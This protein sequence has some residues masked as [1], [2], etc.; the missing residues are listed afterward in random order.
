MARDPEGGGLKIDP[1]TA[2]VD[3][4]YGQTLDP[5]GVCDE[6]ELPD[7]FHCVGHE[8]LLVLLEATSGFIS[9]ICPLQS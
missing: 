3:W 4:N 1:E 6:W 7:E 8:I 2:E 9:A 5:Y